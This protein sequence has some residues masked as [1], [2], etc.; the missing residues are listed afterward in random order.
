LAAHR[1]ALRQR[2][3]AGV[4]VQNLSG[5]LEEFVRLVMQVDQQDQ[6]KLSA[7]LHIG[8]DSVQETQSFLQ[9]MQH[10]IG[11]RRRQAEEL[12]HQISDEV[13][14]VKKGLPQGEEPPSQALLLALDRI[15]ERVEQHTHLDHERSQGLEKKVDHLVHQ[16]QCMAAEIK[17]LESH[18]KQKKFG[19]QRDML[20]GLPSRGAYEEQ[21][22]KEMHR[23]EGGGEGRLVLVVADIDHFKSIND[24]HGHLGGDKVLLA[25]AKVFEKQLRAVDFVARY[26]GEEFVLLLV[27]VSIDEARVLIDSLRDHFEQCAFHVKNEPIEIT[28]SFGL[29]AFI[30]GESSQFL[31]ERADKAL[32]QAKASGRNNVVV[33][34]EI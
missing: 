10:D 30:R 18:L 1:E 26:G 15:V 7:L 8:E 25:A 24:Q 14:V 3:V 9:G 19:V 33:Y 28:M 4:S 20:T 27:D 2:L 22:Q 16:M 23:L 29:T 11:H 6:K 32:Y 12:Q 5:V 34:E 31:F 13:M 21:L 17:G